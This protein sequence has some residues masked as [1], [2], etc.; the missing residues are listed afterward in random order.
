MIYVYGLLKT[1]YNKLDHVPLSSGKKPWQAL[2][3]NSVSKLLL[4]N[5]RTFKHACC[6]IYVGGPSL[7]K[8]KERTPFQY[9]SFAFPIHSTSNLLGKSRDLA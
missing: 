7:A 1:T 4:V 6:M 2:I 3:W 5:V 9:T 8:P